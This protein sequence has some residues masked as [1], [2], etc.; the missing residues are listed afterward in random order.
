MNSCLRRALK[1][2]YTVN[3]MPAIEFVGLIDRRYGDHR[4]FYPLVALVESGY[5]GFTGG[6]PKEDMQFRSSLLAQT[7]QCYRQ[8]RGK[9]SYKN[10]TVFDHDEDDEVYF[11]VGP[12]AIDFFESRRSDTKKLLTSAFLS[13]FA[14]VTVAIIT[15]W[16]RSI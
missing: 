8:G 5:L 6:Q 16:L 11:Y 9:Q 14:A 10:V 3:S 12:R 2:I 7:F 13:F 15:Y 1:K 4:D